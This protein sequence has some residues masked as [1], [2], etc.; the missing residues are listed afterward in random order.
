LEYSPAA[1]GEHTPDPSAALVPAGHHLH[2]EELVAFSALDAYPLEQLLHV[3]G[4]PS[5]GTSSKVPAGHGWQPSE[6]A[7][8]KKPLP[9][10][11]HTD[12]PDL[13]AL[14]VPHTV[15]SMAPPALAENVPPL[16]GKHPCDPLSPTV[17]EYVP[18]GHGVHDPLPLA[19]LYV[20]AGHATH[21]PPFAPV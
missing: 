18:Y 6:L 5:Y 13:A 10:L 1:Q 21:D 19:A 16:H 8:E 12:D 7:V 20:P 9:Q 2:V 3:P 4:V 11:T 14:P 17:G 15:H